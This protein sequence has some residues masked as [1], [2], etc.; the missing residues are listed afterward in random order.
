MRKTQS[1]PPRSSLMPNSA[2]ASREDDVSN[3]SQLIGPKRRK[4]TGLHFQR[5]DDSKFQG[6]SNT[7]LAYGNLR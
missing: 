1:L 6:P 4:A 3:I 5:E 7:G 2:V